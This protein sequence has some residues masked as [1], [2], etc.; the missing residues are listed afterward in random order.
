[1]SNFFSAF[2]KF[3]ANA[4]VSYNSIIAIGD[5]ASNPHHSPLNFVLSKNEDLI[6]VDAGAR[7]FGYC[8]D[9]TW[10]FPVSGKFTKK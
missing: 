6:L 1:M 8:S 9:L 4:T 10:V 2:I 3:Q 5:S 7:L